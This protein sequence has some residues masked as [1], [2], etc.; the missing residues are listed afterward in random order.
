MTKLASNVQPVRGGTDASD[1]T[2]LLLTDGF[3][4]GRSQ[5]WLLCWWHVV[6]PGGRSPAFFRIAK[7]ETVEEAGCRRAGRSGEPQNQTGLRDRRRGTR[8]DDGWDSARPGRLEGHGLREE[9]RFP[10]RFSR[11]HYPSLNLG[12]DGRTRLA[13]RVFAAAAPEGGRSPC[14]DGWSTG[15]DR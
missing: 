3:D 5:G 9:S 8:R 4:G 1:D 2:R 7:P 11:R 10:S 6:Q 15:D 14:R 13:G 12:T